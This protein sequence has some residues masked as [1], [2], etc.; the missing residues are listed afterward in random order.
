VTD[1]TGNRDDAIARRARVRRMTIVL[2]LVALSFY[3]G[4]ILMQVMGAR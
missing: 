4:F 3:I 1:T 2:A